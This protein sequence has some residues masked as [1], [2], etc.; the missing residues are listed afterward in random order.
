MAKIAAM[1]NR[2][3]TKEAPKGDT[4]SKGEDEHI[5]RGKLGSSDRK[6]KIEA[7]RSR[8]GKK[9]K[10]T[11][12]EEKEDLL[13]MCPNHVKQREQER[14][15]AEKQTPEPVKEQAKIESPAKDEPKEEPEKPNKPKKEIVI[16]QP[17]KSSPPRKKKTNLVVER[18]ICQEFKEE[19]VQ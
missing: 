15:E 3:K 4:K 16:T 2:F 8:Y 12:E 14:L 9:K 1:R 5:C 17:G 13:C 18:Q 10:K 6:S 7:L 11:A 19:K